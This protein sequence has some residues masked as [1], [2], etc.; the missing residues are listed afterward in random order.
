MKP[1]RVFPKGKYFW[2]AYWNTQKQD[3][4][5]KP[6]RDEKNQ[7]LPVD[8][9]RDPN[10]DYDPEWF[11]GSKSAKAIRAALKALNMDRVRLENWE[12]TKAS[13]K[14]KNLT[15]AQLL[16]AYNEDRERKAGEVTEHRMTS[17]HSAIAFLET[18]GVKRVRE[19]SEKRVLEIRRQS[20]KDYEASTVKKYFHDLKPMLDLAIKQGSL[21]ENP[22]A[23]VKIEVADKEIEIPTLEEEFEIFDRLLLARPK[24]FEQDLYLR[25]TGARA[26]D[27]CLLTLDRL[28]FDNRVIDFRNNKKKRKYLYPMPET[29]FH[30]LKDVKELDWETSPSNLADKTF[31]WSGGT[32]RVHIFKASFANEVEPFCRTDRLRDYVTHHKPKGIGPKFYLQPPV[33]EAR[34]AINKAQKKWL[35]FIR[36]KT[37][38]K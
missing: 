4:D 25:M 30:L 24:V 19:L 28:D 3:T 37:G 18:Y 34:K 10:A 14:R 5:K 35:D 17:R 38:T 8:V 27:S 36:D 20:L 16:E 22:L 21:E 15:L 11:R 1:P 31:R 32:S 29:V 7:K 26:L 9:K 13:P 23:G 33:D 12:P 2:V 6:L